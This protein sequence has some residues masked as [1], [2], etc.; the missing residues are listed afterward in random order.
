M[1]IE[2]NKV[3]ALSALLA[4]LFA[5]SHAA[6]AQ[7]NS[8]YRNW[9]ASSKRQTVS[10]MQEDKNIVIQYYQ[11][12]CMTKS[13]KKTP[14]CASAATGRKYTVGK[15]LA[16]NT[17][18]R[19]LPND[20]LT[21]LAAL[22]RGYEY[23][24]VDRDVLIVSTRN[25]KV[26]DAVS[27]S[28]SVSSAALLPVINSYVV[29]FNPETTALRSGESRI[30]N[31][32]AR[33]MPQYNPAQVTVTSYADSVVGASSQIPLTDERMNMVLNTLNA[34]GMN[35]QSPSQIT[36][37]NATVVKQLSAIAR[38]QTETVSKELSNRHISNQIVTSN[39]RGSLESDLT[40]EDDTDGEVTQMVVIDFR[41]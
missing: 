7:D 39:A 2:F 23:L 35:L 6:S 10:F 3:F 40:P 1:P 5:F 26:M 24:K 15:S 36:P 19:N 14:D 25:G 31:Q 22:P 27:T 20:L 18:V 4:G 12:Y 28:N 32:I 33:E 17:K 11:R 21:Q 41:K 30:L 29:Y 37:D 9:S 34:F 13:R 16:A 8:P 38:R